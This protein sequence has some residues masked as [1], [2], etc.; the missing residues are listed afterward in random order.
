M[1]NKGPYKANIGGMRL[2]FKELQQ[3]NFKAQEIRV[4]EQLKE[5]WEDINGVLY[6]QDLLYIPKIICSKLISGDHNDPLA[7]HFGIDKT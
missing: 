7:G 1:S 3:E 2:K 6:H 4:T 5:D